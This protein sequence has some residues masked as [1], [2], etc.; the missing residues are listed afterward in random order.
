MPEK[1]RGGGRRP[2]LP[3]R[4]G[5]GARG[6]PWCSRRPERGIPGEK[7]AGGGRGG[8]GRGG[9][10]PPAETGRRVKERSRGGR[11]RDPPAPSTPAPSPTLVAIP[12]S[13][14]TTMQS[15]LCA[16]QAS[17]SGARSVQASPDLPRER[18]PLVS[19]SSSLARRRWFAA[20]ASGGEAASAAP[21]AS[22]VDPTRSLSA[23]MG[24]ARQYVMPT[25]A[26]T[27]LRDGGR[28]GR[29]PTPAVGGRGQPLPAA[30]RGMVHHF[31]PTAR[32]AVYGDRTDE[33][34]ARRSCRTRP[35]ALGWVSDP[36]SPAVRPRLTWRVPP[37]VRRC[38][39]WPAPPRLPRF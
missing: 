3:S 5:P 24:R 38:A 31:P 30:A 6:S 29:A 33:Q 37:L 23:S 21:R 9:R 26:R 15:R 27:K 2:A 12:V 16:P 1:D 17:T 20:A 8:Q 11:R 10:A 25:S 4:R 22:L 19:H 7:E 14:S 13:P 36:P 34:A 28:G 39:P 32:G 18:L 35:P